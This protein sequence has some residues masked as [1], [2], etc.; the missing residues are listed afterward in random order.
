ME[1]YLLMIDLVS[2]E[3]LMGVIGILIFIPITQIITFK[4][5]LNGMKEDMKE[6]KEDGKEV[7][8]DIK[9]LVRKFYAQ[10]KEIALNSQDIEDLKGRVD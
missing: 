8:K 1:I 3:S 4:V 10:D 7:K 9:C 6:V 2:A 5:G